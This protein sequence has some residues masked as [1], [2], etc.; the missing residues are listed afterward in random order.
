M[1]LW[2]DT[3]ARL[4]NIKVD[5]V[6]TGDELGRLAIQRYRELSKRRIF[7]LASHPTRRTAS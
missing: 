2:Q 5:A 1:S 6:V 3:S 4:L 7:L